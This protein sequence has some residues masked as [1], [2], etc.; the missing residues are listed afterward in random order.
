MILVAVVGFPLFYFGPVVADRVH[1]ILGAGMLA[2]ALVCCLGPWVNARMHTPCPWCAADIHPV[3]SHR[4]FHRCLCC[5]FCLRKLDDE[6]PGA[7]KPAKPR[8]D[9]GAFD[10]EFG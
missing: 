6:I 2:T 7:P 9:R 4:D 10:D 1:P 3:V 5:P 8:L